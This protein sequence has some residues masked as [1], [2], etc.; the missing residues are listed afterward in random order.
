MKK[1]IPF[2]CDPPHPLQ[3]HQVSWFHHL[4]ISYNTS[5][6]DGF[7][8]VSTRIYHWPTF[9]LVA[10]YFPVP[11]NRSDKWL[12]LES[13]YIC[14]W[15]FDLGIYYYMTGTFALGPIMPDNIPEWK[16]L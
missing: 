1:L 15:R 6:R 5:S 12:V 7:P 8:G 10:L 13:L 16:S 14:S 3:R 9:S 11:Q 4:L 2:L